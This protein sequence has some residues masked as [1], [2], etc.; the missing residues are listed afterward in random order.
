MR[1]AVH[2]V[3]VLASCL[4]A[5]ALRPPGDDVRFVSLWYCKGGSAFGMYFDEKGAAVVSAASHLYM[6]QPVPSESGRRYV[7][8]EVELIER[9]GRMDLIGAAGGP[10]LDC[11]GDS[12]RVVNPPR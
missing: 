12:R 6:L 4:S 3:I 9:R 8:G 2:A 11:V 7:D 5:C 1:K 10:Y